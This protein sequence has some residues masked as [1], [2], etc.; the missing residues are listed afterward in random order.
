MLNV[1][2]QLFQTEQGGKSGSVYHKTGGKYTAI[3]ILALELASLCVYKIRLCI[4]DCSFKL[5]RSHPST[6]RDSNSCLIHML[7]IPYS[8]IC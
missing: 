6:L 2:R 4:Q 8:V 1:C 3:I 7:S 5:T